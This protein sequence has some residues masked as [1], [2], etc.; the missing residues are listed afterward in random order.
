M[1]LPACSE[2]G[3]P[4]D[5]LRLHRRGRLRDLRAAGRGAGSRRTSARC[6]CAGREAA[7]AAEAAG[8]ADRTGRARHAAARGGSLP[9]RARARRRHVAGGG[10]PR[11]ARAEAPARAG[12]LPGR[13][14]HSRPARRK[15][16][17][18]QVK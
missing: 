4:R 2:S 15:R 3:V 11:V 6:Q 14:D 12:R 10:G 9:V 13:E 8:D 7:E 18:L 5:A 1:M 16:E 17:C